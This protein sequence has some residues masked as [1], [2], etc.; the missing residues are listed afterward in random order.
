MIRAFSF[1]YTLLLMLGTITPT[2]A[3]QPADDQSTPIV[4]IVQAPPFA[5]KDGNGNWDGIA[6][7]LWRHVAGDLGLQ[8]ELREM[9]IPDLVAAIEEGKLTAAVTAAVTAEWERLMDFSHPYYSTGFGIAVPE[10]FAA[11][12]WLAVT[13]N[14][15]SWSFLKIIGLL[16]LVLMI[17]GSL[18]WMFE[19]RANPEQ[20]SDRPLKGIADG[21]WW[22]AVTMTSVGYGDKAPQTQLGRMLAGIWMFAAVVLISFFTAHITSTLTV[23]GLTG[24]VRGPADLPH[25][26][27]GTLQDSAAQS[28]LRA[29]LGIAAGG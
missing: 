4:G 26:R 15:V 10:A 16:V 27:V 12:D 19:R 29:A 2:W 3:A 17:A 22:A 8:Y 21:L 9:S 1:L 25:V 6:V 20:F 5:M 23:T 18:V 24:R 11:P 13:G 14:L 28:Q 7:R